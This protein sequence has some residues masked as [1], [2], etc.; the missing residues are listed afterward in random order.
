MPA[1]EAIGR[2]PAQVLQRDLESDE[3]RARTGSSRSRAAA[4]TSG[5]RS[6]RRSCAIPPA[7]S[8]GRIFAFRDISAEHAVEQMKSDFVST[9]SVELRTPLTSIYGF[10]Q[11]LLRED[12]AFGEAERRTFLEF[13]ARESERLTTIVDALLNVARL[14]TGDLDGHARADRRAPR[15]RRASSTTCGRRTANGHR[16]VARARGRRARRAGRSR[17]AAAGARPADLERRQVLARRRHGHR[18]G[19][20]RATTRSSSPSPTRASASRPASASASSRSSTRPATRRAAAPGSG[21]SSRTGSCARW[22]AG[23]GSIPRRARVAVRVRAAARARTC[24][25]SDARRDNGTSMATKVLVI[26]D[27]AP[28]RLLCR[29]NLEAEGMEVIEAADG[30]SGLETAR[31]EAPDVILLDVMMPGLDGWRV[32]EE[33][34]DDARHREHPDR[35]P[36]RAR[37]AARPCPR[38]RPRRRRL[39]DEAVQPG[40]AGA[41]RA[42]PARARRAAASATSCAARSSASCARPRARV[43][44]RKGRPGRPS[45]SRRC[46]AREVGGDDVRAAVAQERADAD[47]RRPTRMKDGRSRLARCSGLASHAATIPRGR[48]A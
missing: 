26:D 31:A 37:R 3:R 42:R 34:L 30:P 8:P 28:I 21:C 7:R 38:H 19:A 11:T 23:C 41:A 39:R 27:E 45:H 15:D 12:V 29:V 2:T 36:D 46:S 43:A 48:A 18:L 33:L 9:V 1:S 22:A 14:D 20:S 13:I 32:A 47:R 16:F 4:R 5:S 40:R 6:R 44:A 17:Q 24:E 10:A 25:I 35:V